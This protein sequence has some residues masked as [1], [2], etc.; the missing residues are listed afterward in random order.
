[1]RSSVAPS[2]RALKRFRVGVQGWGFWGIVLGAFGVVFWFVS[3]LVDLL[4]CKFRA[5]E[6]FSGLGVLG[7]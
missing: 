6:G 4:G 7:F 1:M 5:L 2:S 3:L